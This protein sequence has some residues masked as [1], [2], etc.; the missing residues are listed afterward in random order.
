MKKIQV[1]V[2]DDSVI[3]R[4]I[5]A[6]QLSA[7]PEIEVTGT[8]GDPF[9]ARNKLENG[10]FDV[11][12]LD[13]EM[14]RM[15]GLTFLK[16]LM[17]YKPLPVIVVSSI[18]SNGNQAALEALELGAVDVVR[19]PGGP[20]SVEEVIEELSAKIIEAYTIPRSR[21][22]TVSA[23]LK[24]RDGSGFQKTLS[25]IRTT[26][27][28]AVVGASTG[29]TIA[30]EELFSHF[31]SD[32]PSALVVI[33]M[34]E[35]FTA[36]FARRLDGLCQLHVKEAENGEL[37]MPGTIYIAPGG[38]HMLVGTSGAE[39]IIRIK[40]GPKL[41]GQR[42]AVDVLF[43]SAAENIGRNCIAALLTGM[44]RDGAAGM[45]SIRDAGGYTIAQNEETSIVFGMPKEAIALGGACE[46]TPLD[47]IAESIG[48][49]V[50]FS[51]Q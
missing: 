35:H 19:K 48:R 46:V 11:V 6:R 5:L 21:L 50:Q 22:Q 37:V 17:K 1:L 7:S 49:H 15:D 3:V 14:P 4:D 51:I 39:R 25:R 9:I 20:F 29:G 47:K 36:S 42:P 32:F 28:L 24:N 44:G 10:S 13:I 34:P 8:A 30:L 38:S 2:I 43:K 18:V 23:R 40:N 26:N 27:R 45:K 33:H 41:F 12:T 31:T 16:Y